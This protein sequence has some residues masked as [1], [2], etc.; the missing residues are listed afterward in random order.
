[1]FADS[2]PGAHC[3][4]TFPFL[5]ADS[6]YQSLFF[7]LCF[8]VLYPTLCVSF[9]FLSPCDQPCSILPFKF[10]IQLASLRTIPSTY[11][12]PFELFSRVINTHFQP[13]SRPPIADVFILRLPQSLP[14][15]PHEFYPFTVSFLVHAKTRRFAASQLFFVFTIFISPTNPCGVV[16]QVPFRLLADSIEGQRAVGE[17]G[18]RRTP[19]I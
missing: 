5:H 6:F 3:S 15:P 1:L 18:R 4:K 19:L 17:F 14:P 16:D 9:L 13:S 7:F 8:H 2:R 10:L 11:M 12:P